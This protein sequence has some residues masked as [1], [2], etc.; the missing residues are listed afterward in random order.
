VG[1]RP[2]R[3]GR[4]RLH[5]SGSPVSTFVPTW[6]DVKAAWSAGWKALSDGANTTH[7]RAAEA[8]PT[9]TLARVSSFLDALADSRASLDRVATPLP[10]PATT[11]QDVAFVVQHRAL[12]GH[13]H[14]LAAGSAREGPREPDRAAGGQAE[15][16]VRHDRSTSQ[17][18][19]RVDDATVGGTA[20]SGSDHCPTSEHA[21][22]GPHRASAPEV[23][24]VR[25]RNMPNMPGSREPGTGLQAAS[26]GPVPPQ[27]LRRA[28][29]RAD[30]RARR[31]GQ[32]SKRSRRVSRSSRLHP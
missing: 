1:R 5:L 18:H 31:K 3:R 22:H 29:S 19:A 12:E 9:G 24:I 15:A 4:V 7:A 26:G 28:R 30:T 11:P 17:G 6:S 27:R 2:L 13:Y 14:D 16:G 32:T 25:R 8:D 23:T 10:N 20:P 21:Q